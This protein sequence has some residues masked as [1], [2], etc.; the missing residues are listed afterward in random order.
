MQEAHGLVNIEI[1][2]QCPPFK[3]DDVEKE[4]QEEETQTDEQMNDG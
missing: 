4:K 3:K 1:L 2:V